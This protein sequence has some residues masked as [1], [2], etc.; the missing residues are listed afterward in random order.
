MLFWYGSRNAGPFDSRLN[1]CCA[2]MRA[3]NLEGSLRMTVFWF[4]LRAMGIRAVARYAFLVRVQK[5]RSIRLASELLLRANARNEFGRLAQ[6][7]SVLVFAE[8]YGDTSGGSICFFGTGP[9]MQ[10]HSTRV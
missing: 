3:T 8:S 4:L 9:E 5:C 7:D 10:V 2:Q 1:C 6:D